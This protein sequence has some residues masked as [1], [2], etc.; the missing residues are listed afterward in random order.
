[1]SI[2][3][4]WTSNLL[5]TA[6]ILLAPVIGFA[7]VVVAEMVIDA[8]ARLGA[9]VIWTVVAGVM[10]WVLLRKYGWLPC[11]SQLGSGEA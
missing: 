10:G 2:V 3:R 8:L 11:I 7:V 5:L 6:L 1:M 9:P 4:S